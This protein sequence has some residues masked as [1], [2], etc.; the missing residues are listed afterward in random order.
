MSRS[1]KIIERAVAN[2]WIRFEDYRSLR[3]NFI[4]VYLEAAEAEPIR[5]YLESRESDSLRDD[6]L[7]TGEESTEFEPHSI[8]FDPLSIF[9]KVYRAL[10]V[11]VVLIAYIL[12]KTLGYSAE[13]VVGFLD[14]PPIA[15][16]LF[17][18]GVPISWLLAGAAYLLALKFDSNIIRLMND[19][20]RV[21]DERIKD[22]DLKSE[23][24]SFY[25][26][27]HSLTSNTTIPVLALLVMVRALSEE[28]VDDGFR[29]AIIMMAYILD[30]DMNFME[31]L[32]ATSKKISTEDE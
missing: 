7:A 24:F 16:I 18:Y 30:D 15:S 6:A 2:R 9:R 10:W 23:I 11:I 4:S 31:A 27:N 17:E 1:S 20:L 32:G 29:F 28:L 26:W 5:E 13:L 12:H 21:K 19:E 8:V 22:S 14:G 25:L 3:E